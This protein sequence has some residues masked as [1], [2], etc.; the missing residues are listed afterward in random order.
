MLLV[1][2]LR[3]AE[4]FR[5]GDKCEG[6]SGLLIHENRKTRVAA[7]VVRQSVHV[8]MDGNLVSE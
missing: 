6:P 1:S 8:K 5:L 7:R 2:G 4:I 3:V